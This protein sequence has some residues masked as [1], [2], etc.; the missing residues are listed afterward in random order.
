MSMAHDSSHQQRESTYAL[1]A[2]SAAEL[3]RLM[4]QDRMFTTEIGGLFPEVEEVD[5]IKD[6]L[7]IACG[8]GG[9]VLDT[10]F[11]YPDKEV[12]GI[13][14]SQRMIAYAQGQAKVQGLDNAQ[15]QLMNALDPL[16]FPDASFDLINARLILAFML[17]SV[18]PQFLLE[19]KRVLR[20]GGIIR[21]TELEWGMSNMPA[22]E[23][24]SGLS[25]L[26]LKRAGQS[27]SP[28]GIHV[29]ILPVLPRL[30]KNAGFQAV[31][32]QAYSID[33][34]YGA[35]SH[36]SFYEDIKIAF[37]LLQ[38]FML[39]WKAIDSAEELETL[40]QQALDEMQ[41]EEFCACTPLLTV[42]GVKP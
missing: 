22:F 41:A 11:Q 37:K 19:C 42:L 23:R 18:W 13:D 4:R 34:S 6:I 33:F 3:A 35:D 38:P 40:Y 12:T 30:V 27:F 31:K 32:R 7:D 26:A 28:S 20:P 29:G 25:M 39:R 14:I 8:P 15:F 1:D 24:L 2:E 16:K 36:E 17:P 9:W 10:A 5:G 21:L